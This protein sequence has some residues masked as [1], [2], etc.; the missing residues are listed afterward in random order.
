MSNSSDSVLDVPEYPG[1]ESATSTAFQT[2]ASSPEPRP[3]KAFSPESLAI[4]RAV[5]NY[6]DRV[7]LEKNQPNDSAV[8]IKDGSKNVAT[9]TKVKYLVA[10]FMLSLVLTLSNKTIMIEVR[11][12]HH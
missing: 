10:Y 3:T 6:Y 8:G 9:S 2:R 1:G 5:Q 11:S 12:C 7:C 4:L